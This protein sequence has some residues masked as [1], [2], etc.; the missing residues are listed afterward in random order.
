MNFERP[1]QRT[2]IGIDTCDLLVDLV[3]EPDLSGYS[4]KD[5][6]EY[7]QGRR[8]GFIDEVDHV[9][10]DD[11]RQQVLALIESRPGPFAQ[12]LSAWRPD[13]RWPA[14]ALP[15]DALTVPAALGRRHPTSH[16]GVQIRRQ[17]SR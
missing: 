13:P 11:A 3:V 4:W 14:P 17:I 8:L 6:D 2:Q 7:E 16:A 10:V 1:C 15:A 12:D 9:A 5:E